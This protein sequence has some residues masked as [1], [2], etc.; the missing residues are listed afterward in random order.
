MT[1]EQAAVMEEWMKIAAPGE[2]H[3]HLDYFVGKWKTK[4][5]MYMGGP[6]STPMVSEGTSE[7]KWVLDGRFIMD[8]HQGSMMG[9]PYKGIGLTG[10]DN[11]R[12]M[13]EGSWC[14]NMGTNYLTMKG[15]HQLR[16]LVVQL[17]KME[18]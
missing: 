18:H 14:S 4:T 2:H 10:Y 8:T 16:Q 1:P 11:Y 5:S 7:M 3:K 12:N 13:Y 15:E 17:K 9:Q 6:G